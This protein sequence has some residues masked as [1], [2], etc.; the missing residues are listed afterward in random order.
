MSE[1]KK[2]SLKDLLLGC[3]PRLLEVLE[4]GADWVWETDQDHRFTFLSAQMGRTTSLKL[5]NFIG[6]RRVDKI[7][8]GSVSAEALAAHLDDL[9]HH[10]AFKEFEYRTKNPAAPGGEVWCS[11]SGFPVFDADGR[12]QGYRGSGCNISDRMEAQLARKRAEAELREVNATLERR[13]A[14][15]TAELEASNTRLRERERA[16]EMAS[17]R[18]TEVMR[19]RSELFADFS[20]DLRTPLNGMIGTN[21]LLQQT[22]LSARQAELSG[23]IERSA[24]SLLDLVNDLMDLARIEAGVIELHPE[25]ID[26]ARVLQDAVDILSPVA[27]EKGVPLDLVKRPDLPREIEADP[28]RLRQILLNLLGNA[29]KFTGPEGRIALTAGAGAIGGLRCEVEDTGIGIPKDQQDRVF[30]RFHIAHGSSCKS[31][32][33]LGLAICRQ[34][35]ECMQGTIGVE[36][37]PGL[38]STFWVELPLKPRL[39]S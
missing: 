20:H 16:L 7:I 19:V 26:P 3:D 11:V 30:E 38:G 29:I 2:T 37:A 23:V 5:E 34:L 31:S 35:T 13:I 10:R 32:T 6:S 15:R 1:P 33:G 21:L 4:A 24:R 14:E 28:A 36:S 27:H 25:V 39:N 9:A 18:A 17:R 12:F 8:E 22:K